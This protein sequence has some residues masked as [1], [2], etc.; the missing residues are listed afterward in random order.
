MS[1][2]YFVPAV[3]TAIHWGNAYY[4]P[5]YVPEEHGLF[6]R[7]ARLEEQVRKLEAVQVPV[8]PISFTPGT[9]CRKCQEISGGDCGGHGPTTIRY[10]EFSSWTLCP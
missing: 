9:W 8:G 10:S 3:G 2:G 6:D 1:E 7:I 4:S 5:D